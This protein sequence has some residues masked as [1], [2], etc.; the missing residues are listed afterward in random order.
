MRSD[1]PMVGD[2]T[3]RRYRP[4]R[5]GPRPG[6]GAQP[7]DR[8]RRRRP[9]PVPDYRD[10]M[11]ATD[12][13]R[14]ARR[15]A[16]GLAAAFAAAGLLAGCG[17]GAGAPSPAWAA[18]F[19]AASPAAATAPATTDSDLARG[20]LPADAFGPGATV[21]PV[22]LAQLQQHLAAVPGGLA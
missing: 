10:A 18:P 5:P 14:T 8:A 15:S 2:P 3:D 12:R 11:R 20:L 19:G 16:A 9:G 17:G 21:M 4:V 7:V 1:R 22:T 13:S 6:R